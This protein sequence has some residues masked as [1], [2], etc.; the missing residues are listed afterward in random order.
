MIWVKISFWGS[1]F[2]F[3]PEKQQKVLILAV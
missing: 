1:R 2:T 3:V